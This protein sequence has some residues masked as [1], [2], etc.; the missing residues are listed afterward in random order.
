MG[1]VLVD[2]GQC[3]VVD[4]SAANAAG[5]ISRPIT[6]QRGYVPKFQPGK[7]AFDVCQVWIAPDK[8]T[9]KR[10]ARDTIEVTYEIEVGVC[11]RV[12]DVSNDA[13]DP[14][15]LLIQEMADLFFCYPLSNPIATWSENEVMYWGDPLR[16]K[17]DGSFFA[18][19][20]AKFVGLRG[21]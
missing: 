7:Q 19:W 4:Y 3:V 5:R 15:K 16:L 20:V 13:V 8:E 17:M 2:V 11:G 10:V 14:W 9:S 12:R 1:A 6:V 21:R 18:L